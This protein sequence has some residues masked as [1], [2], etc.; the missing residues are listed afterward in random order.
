MPLSDVSSPRVIAEADI[1]AALALV[2]TC[3]AATNLR[4]QQL[5]SLPPRLAWSA[6]SVLARHIRTILR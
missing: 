4:L 1:E 5:L 3:P 2:T 6:A